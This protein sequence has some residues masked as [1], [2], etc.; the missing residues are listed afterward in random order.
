MMTG[1]FT[2][3]KIS[4]MWKIETLITHVR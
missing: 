4:G 3:A 2:S 1:I